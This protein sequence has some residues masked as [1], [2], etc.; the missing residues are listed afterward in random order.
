VAWRVAAT[1]AAVCRF[2]HV[3]GLPGVVRA[4]VPRLGD[5]AVRIGR[6]HRVLVRGRPLRPQSVRP[7]PSGGY[8]RGLAGRLRRSRDVPGPALLPLAAEDGPHVRVRLRS[9]GR[10]RKCPAHPGHGV[11]EHREHELLDRSEHLDRNPPPGHAQRALAKRRPFRIELEE[12]L[13][14][15]RVLAA[16]GR[17]PILGNPSK[18][19]TITIQ[20]ST[21]SVMEGQPGRSACQFNRCGRVAIHPERH[22]LIGLRVPASGVGNRSLRGDAADPQRS[23]R[24]MI[25]SALLV[26]AKG[27]D[28]SLRTSRKRRAP[29]SIAIVLE[30]TPCSSRRQERI[31]KKHSTRL[32]RE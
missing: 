11:L 10:G 13:E 14:R 9:R 21:R 26:Q 19:Q 30:W 6:G 25:G 18:S 32:S 15:A 4:T 20:V 16:R 22:G 5:L 2:H 27:R 1:V 24:A 3:L 8:R 12:A 31:E 23:I 28:W 7:D 17:P 29:S